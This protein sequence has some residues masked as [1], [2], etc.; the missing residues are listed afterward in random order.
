MDV[1]EWLWSV[2]MPT[3]EFCCY[4][5]DAFKN[6]RFCF[7]LY[8]S[9]QLIS[10]GCPPACGMSASGRV[11][12]LR[13]STGSRGC[14]MSR[15]CSHVQQSLSL[16]FEFGRSF[17]LRSYIIPGKKLAEES[18]LSSASV[19]AETSI[20]SPWK[21]CIY[22]IKRV[23]SGSKY[24]KNIWFNFENRSTDAVDLLEGNVA[25]DRLIV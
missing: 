20:R 24:P 12:A 3:A 25:A 21:L 1:F 11:L 16:L 8:S 22:I 19:L 4:V 7:T 13:S 17:A 10:P 23:F 9:S 14:T 6:L 5:T 2:S 18:S 15:T